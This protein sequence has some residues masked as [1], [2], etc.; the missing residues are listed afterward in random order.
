MEFTRTIFDSIIRPSRP[1]KRLGG[2]IMQVNIYDA[3]THFTELINSLKAEDEIIIARRGTP[4]AKLVPYSESR[5]RK[6]G[7]AKGKYNIPVTTEKFDELNNEI[8]EM[9]GV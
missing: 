7:V 2:N 6:L 9:F 5:K 8:A 4:V 1:S 3:K